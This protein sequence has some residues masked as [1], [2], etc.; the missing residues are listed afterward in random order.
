MLSNSSFVT[1]L[2]DTLLNNNTWLTELQ[3]SID[4]DDQTIDVLTLTGDTLYISLED[5]GVATQTLDLSPLADAK[6]I[7]DL[8][9]GKSDSDGSNDGSSIFL[10]I[11]AGAADDATNNR[12]I[13][14]GFE[15]LNANT[16]GFDN[17][18][19]GSQALFSNT[20]GHGNI[21]TGKE[22]LT[23]NTTGNDNVATGYQSLFSNTTGHGNI[24]TGSRALYSNTTGSNNIATGYQSLY[25]NTTGSNNIAT[26]FG[27]LNS[28]TTGYRNVA[29]GIQAL[30]ANITGYQ[31]IATGFF[32]LYRNTTGYGNVATGYRS[33][34]E[35]TTGYD[36]V[37][38]GN[39]ALN[40]NTTGTHNTAIGGEQALYSNTEGTANVAIGTRS[41]IFNKIGN[42]NT[43]IGVEAGA[44]CLGDGNVYI[45]YK[46]GYNNDTTSNKLYIENTGASST[47]ALIYGEF[48][49]DNTA[50]GNILRTN[51]EFQI[52]DPAGT[53]YKF[54]AARGT[55]NQ[56][57]ITDANGV[58]TW[59]NTSILGTDDQN[60]SGSGL[61]G[62]T[63]TI[64]IEN[65][66]NETV[67]LSSLSTNIF[68][69]NGT[70]TG[71]RTLTG[72]GNSL[73]FTNLSAF[74][75]TTAAGQFQLGAD[76]K[77]TDA[78]AAGSQHGIEYA[79]DYS[80]DYTNRSLVDKEFVDLQ[81]QWEIVGDM[82]RPKNN[83][84]RRVYVEENSNSYT[85]FMVRNNNDTGNG[86]GAIIELKGSGADF[87]NNM[88]IGKYGASFWIP[89]LTG[90]GAV[91]TD[92][93]LV[94]GT[95]SANHE[96]HFV[97]GNSYVDLRPVVVADNEGFRY[98]SDLSATFVDR[99]LVDKQYVDN[100]IPAS[101]WAK[102]GTTLS[103][104]TAGDNVQLNTGDSLFIV[105]MTQGSIPFIGASGLVTQD[106][107]NLFW[108]AANNRLGV[109]T[110][111]PGSAMH[112]KSNAVF[113]EYTV[114]TA[115]SKAFFGVYDTDDEMYFNG[116]PGNTL[117][118]NISTGG[119]LENIYL[120]AGTGNFGIHT[121]NPSE[122]LHVVGNG[123]ITGNLH[124]H[125]VYLDS[126]NEPGT[127][128]QLLSST[129]TG[130]DW[131]DAS[132]VGT[133]DQNISGSGL[134]GTTLTIGIENGTSE[135]VDLSSLSTITAI[136]TQTANYTILATDG[137]ILVDA[138]G[139][140]VTITLPTPV[141][142]KK[143]IVKKIDTSANNVTIA[144]TGG[145]TI[146]GAATQ[147]TGVAYQ[148]Y[149]LQSD[150][151]NWYIIN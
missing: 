15:A 14:I 39:R 23:S 34:F 102:T 10:G 80:A 112:I 41:L 145:A 70:L 88:Y 58:L 93:N 9:D 62:T 85:Q 81:M 76:A 115:N 69:N 140:A 119:A 122:R 83:S 60:I 44:N 3:D 7:D 146:D 51:S 53:G 104:A 133:D 11:G 54:P 149:V 96:I 97:T 131:V 72:G 103:P 59:N 78:R 117:N 77:W 61:S 106:N 94:I 63:L 22:S 30:H 75:A 18:A 123:Y 109:G 26:G 56:V 1:N 50:T 48:G 25:F 6:K 52:G 135:T 132:S 87:T 71:N 47:T 150:G 84:V 74:G 20:T 89:E 82:I 12:N 138:T 151:T 144:T 43:A 91:M 64:G 73:S 101:L 65:G 147:T 127:A 24:A 98:T 136:S 27:S 38:T 8:T 37:A 148:T 99:T 143:Y 128:G 45:G 107:S 108:D 141:S 113:E 35:N 116:S 111:A 110:N 21:A 92:K 79:A 29:T 118:V 55:A 16:I 57:L 120:Q 19:T 13:G 68:N 100:A 134:S 137:T 90:N 32:S 40:S 105:D 86:A 124:V 114:E 4:T 142:G 5:D 36:N 139:G 28:N 130:T 46:A 33:L 67:D 42:N 95:A 121:E 17:V 125:G 49:T 31:N 66:S 2:G 129:A 126:N